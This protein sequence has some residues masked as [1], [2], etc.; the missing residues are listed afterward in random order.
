MNSYATEALARSRQI[1]L[2]READR[3]SL[4]RSARRR[5]SKLGAA[6]RHSHRRVVAALAAIGLALTAVAAI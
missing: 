6:A 4:S 5:P 3:L 1:D 2:Q